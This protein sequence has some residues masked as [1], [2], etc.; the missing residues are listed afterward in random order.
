MA[1]I[2]EKENVRWKLDS[3]YKNKIFKTRNLWLIKGKDSMFKSF[4]Y[5]CLFFTFSNGLWASII[6]RQN[7]KQ[8][9]RQGRW[10]KWKTTKSRKKWGVKKRKT[11]EKQRLSVSSNETLNKRGALSIQSITDWEALVQAPELWESPSLLGKQTHKAML[12]HEGYQLQ[13]RS[14]RNIVI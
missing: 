11:E 1:R 2:K 7:W 14:E 5:W 13:L 10:E 12:S 3:T 4:L 9:V 8:C 6:A